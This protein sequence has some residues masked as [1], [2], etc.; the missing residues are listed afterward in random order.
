[1]LGVSLR[2]MV[3]FIIGIRRHV[4]SEGRDPSPPPNVWKILRQLENHSLHLELVD[5]IDTF[6]GKLAMLGQ[7][8]LAGKLNIS[9]RIS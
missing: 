4:N 8:T 7:L 6:L 9:I 2:L 3:K 1:M 5:S